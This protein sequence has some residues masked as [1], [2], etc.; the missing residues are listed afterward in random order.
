[1]TIATWL[2]WRGLDGILNDFAIWD[3]QLSSE[4]IA[5]VYNLAADVGMGAGMANTMFG[6]YD[7][8]G[9]VDSFVNGSGWY[10][11]YD[12][13]DRGLGAAGTV[14][15]LGYLD[16]IYGCDYSLAPKAHYYYLNRGS[17]VVFAIPE[18]ASLTLLALGCLG[19][20]RRRQLPAK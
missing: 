10:A 13:V 18:P 17:G 6:I 19:L 1:M 12:S 5:A 2:Y 20:L 4:E 8:A 15:Y 7:A 16:S 3:E 11:W 9:A 14:T